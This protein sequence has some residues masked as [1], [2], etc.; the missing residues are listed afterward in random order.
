LDSRSSMKTLNLYQSYEDLHIHGEGSSIHS[1]AKGQL[2]KIDQLDE[3]NSYDQSNTNNE[4]NVYSILIK[5]KT[6]LII[7]SRV[8]EVH[9]RFW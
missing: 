4:E 3:R 1:C 9:G 8:P 7:I 2:K 5:S 6:S